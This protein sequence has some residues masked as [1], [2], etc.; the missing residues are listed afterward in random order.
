MSAPGRVTHVRVFVDRATVTRVKREAVQAGLQEV[1]F[2]GLPQSVEPDTVRALARAGEA[3]VPVVSV[4]A[5]VAYAEP[6]AKRRAEVEAR[7]DALEAK[8]RASEDAQGSDEHAAA[9]L[10]RYAELASDHLSVEWLDGDPDFGRW[11][12]AFD[13]L[14]ASHARLAGVQAARHQEVKT[15][16]EQRA[17]LERELHRLGERTSIGHDVTVT[18]EVPEGAAGEIEVEL[19]YSTR[20]AQWMPAYDARL[21]EAEGGLEVRWTAVA[22]VKQ[23]TGEDW[24]GVSLVATT[25][26]PPLSEPAPELVKV[27]VSGRA[28][29]PDRDV[30]ARHDA[31]ARLGGGGGAAPAAPAQVEHAAEGAVSVPSTARPVRV[32]LFESTLPAKRRLEVAPMTR[33]V[34]T[35]V[36]ELDNTSGRVLLPGAVSLFRGPNYSGRTELGFVTAGE[37]FRLPLATE[38]GL[39]IERRIHPHPRRETAVT[40]AQTYAY[41]GSTKVENVGAEPVSL[42]LLERVPVSRSEKVSVEVD[43]LPAGAKLDEETGRFEV[44]VEIAPGATRKIEWAFRINAPRGVGVQPPGLL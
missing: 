36:L 25:A 10:Q 35:W 17:E 9:Q 38:G 8:L 23:M 22:L 20:S 43:E 44:E 26:R 33:P 7:L 16:R 27:F 3:A 4:N 2:T 18:L 37:R 19:S 13:Q 24:S 12:Q 11:A 39:R 41:D 29:G 14:R 1:A 42:W 5:R 30:V 31:G 6:S 40:G 28:A 32:D 21:V 34:A 15:L